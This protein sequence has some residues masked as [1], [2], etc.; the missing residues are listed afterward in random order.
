M[1]PEATI[2]STTSATAVRRLAIARCIS[3][4]G[5]SAAFAALNFLVYGRTR[6]TAWLA[7]TLLL[8]FGAAVAASPL[9]GVIGDRFDRRRVMICS[10]LAA[11]ALFA[12]MS[13]LHSVGALVTV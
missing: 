11:G 8:T 6:S 3:Q 12:A 4:T 10:D 13:L 7:A 1:F 2:R 9:A 5:T